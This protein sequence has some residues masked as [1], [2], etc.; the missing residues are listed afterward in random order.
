MKLSGIIGDKLQ[1]RIDAEKKEF[2][3][4]WEIRA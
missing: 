1:S 2:D 4:L 3:R